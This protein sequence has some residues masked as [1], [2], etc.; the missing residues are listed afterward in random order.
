MLTWSEVECAQR[1][2]EILGYYIEYY[3]MDTVWNA[4]FEPGIDQTGVVCA[5]LTPGATYTF[6]VAARNEHGTGNFSTPV[7]VV[8]G[9][10]GTV[11]IIMARTS[12]VF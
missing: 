2:G 3:S 1:N 4:T 7:E 12:V 8:I 11:S 6:R 5:G 9:E 10:E